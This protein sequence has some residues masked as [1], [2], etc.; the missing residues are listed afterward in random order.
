MTCLCY[1]NLDLYKHC[2]YVAV[3]IIM[4]SLMGRY[5]KGRD[6]NQILWLFNTLITVYTYG[7]T[8]F[9]LPILLFPLDI[10]ITQY[11]VCMSQYFEVL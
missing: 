4:L 7:I 5:R 2:L 8:P 1:F 11:S 9:R 3:V 6:I 10:L